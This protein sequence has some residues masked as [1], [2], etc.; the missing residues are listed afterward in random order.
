MW[1]IIDTS[2]YIGHWER[3][4]YEETLDHVR[5]AFVI[6]GLAPSAGVPLRSRGA[7]EQHLAH[8]L[9]LLHVAVR[10]G[11]QLLGK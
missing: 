9:A 10:R 1:A 3:G 7:V 8:V 5:K 6:R 11:A 4:L 2:V